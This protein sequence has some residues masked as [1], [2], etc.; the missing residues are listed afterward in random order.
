MEEVL[1]AAEIKPDVLQVEFHPYYQQS[2]LKA[3][4]APYG[5]AIE[6]RYPIGHGDRGLIGRAAVVPP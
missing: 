6:S 5:K 1:S 2:A 4:I 3:R